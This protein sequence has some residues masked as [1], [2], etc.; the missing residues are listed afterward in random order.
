MIIV[1]LFYNFETKTNSDHICRILLVL[2]YLGLQTIF[3]SKA[4]S[5]STIFVNE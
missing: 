2:F 3:S 1:A 5:T 4:L